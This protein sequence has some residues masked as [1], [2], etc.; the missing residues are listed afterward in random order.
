VITDVFHVA[1]I[2]SLNTTPHCEMYSVA[3]CTTVT[4]L[5][6]Y[7]ILLVSSNRF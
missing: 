3:N 1:C 2:S 4:L 7:C 6:L 5:S